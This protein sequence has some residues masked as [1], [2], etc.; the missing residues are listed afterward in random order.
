MRI[1]HL[2]PPHSDPDRNTPDKQPHATHISFRD[3]SHSDS[4]WRSWGEESGGAGGEV[5]GVGGAGVKGREVKVLQVRVLEVKVQEVE[6]KMLEVEVL[7][8]EVKGPGVEVLEVKVEV[9]KL[10][11]VLGWSP[12]ES[13]SSSD[14]LQ[15]CEVLL[16]PTLVGPNRADGP[17]KQQCLVSEDDDC[18]TGSEVT[19]DE[20]GDEEEINKKQAAKKAKKP[21]R[22]LKKQ[23]SSPNF[24][25]REK[26]DKAPVKD[27]T[28]FTVSVQKSKWDTSRSLRYNQDLQRE[29]DQRRM[30]E[31]IEHLTQMRFGDQE[32]RTSKDPQE[33]SGGIYSR[34]EAQF[35]NTIQ[36]Q[37]NDKMPRSKTRY[38]QIKS[39]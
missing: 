39:T 23:L 12:E 32:P 5:A 7:E 28:P 24:S 21:P 22:P 19:E 16:E 6:V 36:R 20:V 34:L 8:V 14:K 3:P 27:S 30:T 31:I 10:L 38:A 17:T 4:R 13:A 2:K 37:N 29:E 1:I 25:R 11:E 15:E 9:L 26:N 33:S 18:T 35:R